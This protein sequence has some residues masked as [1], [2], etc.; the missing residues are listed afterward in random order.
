M[1]KQMV[2]VLMVSLMLSPA[3]AQPQMV[4]AGITPDSP[5]WALDKA[6]E[7]ASIFITRDAPERIEK[8]TGYAEERLKE[9]Q[10]MLK[11]NKSEDA[12]RAM[13][14]HSKLMNDCRKDIEES[15]NTRDIER[16]KQAFE[17][18]QQK[19]DEV[20]EQVLEELP[21]DSPA[22]DDV[23]KAFDKSRMGVEEAQE[24]IQEREDQIEQERKKAFT[25]AEKKTG[26]AISKAYKNAKEGKISSSTI[27]ETISY[28]NANY[29]LSEF[30]GESGCVTIKNGE[31]ACGHVKDGVLVE[32][33]SGSVTY[34]ITLTQEDIE[35]IMEKAGEG[36][37]SKSWILKE[38]GDEIGMAGVSKM[39]TILGGNRHG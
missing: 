5:L 29:N 20:E 25:N 14:E 11:E 33:K 36:E 6:A 26:I 37:M 32:G 13:E 39:K 15:S 9:Y 2:A 18:H 1:L 17:E 28:I 12:N 21:E 24:R 38:Y 7:K 23:E 4:E 19:M 22:R 31:T 34:D 10:E 8:R 3:Y 27:Q 30:E 16:A 35:E